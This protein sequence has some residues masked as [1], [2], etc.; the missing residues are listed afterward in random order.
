MF[1]TRRPVHAA[2]YPVRAGGD[3]PGD[4][5]VGANSLSNTE[6]KNGGAIPPLHHTSCHA[7]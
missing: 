6:A 3:F 7:R 2:S 1:S 5:E 4:Q